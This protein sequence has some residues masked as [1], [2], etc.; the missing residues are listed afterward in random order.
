M[1]NISPTSEPANNPDLDE[2]LNPE[3]CE[4]KWPVEGLEPVELAGEVV[5]PLIDRSLITNELLAYCERF[6]QAGRLIMSFLDDPNIKSH[7]CRSPDFFPRFYFL[8]HKVLAPRL[9][10]PKPIQDFAKA[11][12]KAMWIKGAKGEPKKYFNL[13]LE[14]VGDLRRKLKLEGAENEKKAIDRNQNEPI[15]QNT[16]FTIEEKALALLVSHPEGMEVKS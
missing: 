15:D 6:L 13:A 10:N 2:I 1:K 8:T 16:P 9:E 7:V 4:T 14:V 12:C 11:V 5:W 3:L